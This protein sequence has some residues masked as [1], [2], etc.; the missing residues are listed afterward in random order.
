MIVFMTDWG[1]SHYVG[2]C[3]G[4]MRKIANVEVVDLT[5]DIS[6]FNVREAMYILSRSFIHF[7]KGS[8]FLCVVDYGVGSSRKAIAA[9]TE[10]YYFVGPDNGIFTL[11]FEI[12]KPIEIRELNNKEFYYGDSQTFHGRDIFSPAAAYIYLGKFEQ[13]G[14]QLYNYGT[15]P[16]IKPK[17]SGNNIRGEIAYID[18]F[19]NIETN[20]PYD[21]IKDFEKVTIVKNRKRIEIPIANYYSEVEKGQLLL[22]N[23]ST[24]YVEIAANQY[25]ANDILK[26]NTGDLLELI[27]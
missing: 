7:P 1:S 14:D 18:K 8:I 22:H 24:G 19:G 20:I 26:F 3:K 11:A 21:W 4:V 2:I 13:L 25:R 10:N 6:S 17:R 12:E 23:D 27:L 16:Y 9:K 15:L 5:H